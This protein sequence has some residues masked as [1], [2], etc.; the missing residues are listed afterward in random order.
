MGSIAELTRKIQL[1]NIINSIDDEVLEKAEAAYEKIDKL[2]PKHQSEMNKVI[3]E[4]NGITVDQL[5]M[6]PNMERLAG[7]YALH[8]VEQSVKILMEAGMTEEQARTMME[9]NL[10]HSE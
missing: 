1:V 4:H 7:N 9:Y 5:V 2:A 8:L 6:S 3:A 10:K